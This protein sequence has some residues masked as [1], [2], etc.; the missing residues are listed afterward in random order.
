MLRHSV[1]IT[2]R[3]AELIRS[4]RY[5]KYMRAAAAVLAALVVAGWAAPAAAAAPTAPP[6]VPDADGVLFKDDPSIV[7]PQPLPVES[8]SREGERAV[9]VHFTTG[10]PACNGVHATTHETADAVTIDLKGGALPPVAGRMC[11]MLAVTGTLVV[12][13]GSPLGDRQVLSA[14]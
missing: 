7:D 11:I 6:E 10:T 14:G 8:W 12:P 4:C 1:F 5:R 2:A 3:R 13:L 9:A